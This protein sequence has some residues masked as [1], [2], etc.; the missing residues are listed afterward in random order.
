MKRILR[1]LLIAIIV[2]LCIIGLVKLFGRPKTKTNTLNKN[3]VVN[4]RSKEKI[5][6]TDEE[7]STKEKEEVKEEPV[8]EKEP[9]QE[10]VKEEPV[11]ENVPVPTKKAIVENNV[12]VLPNNDPE[13]VTITEKNTSNQS[14]I[15]SEEPYNPNGNHYN[16][17]VQDNDYS[18]PDKIY[19]ERCYLN[20]NRKDLYYIT[21]CQT[22]ETANAQ[23]KYTKINGNK[24]SGTITRSQL[25]MAVSCK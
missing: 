18:Y 3:Q 16:N 10:E 25:K 23:C 13:P 6:L 8:V 15:E 19:G 17:P 4:V 22:R 7:K 1:F 5:K 24:S 21:V 20:G 12:I 11:V 9:V 2:L 14:I